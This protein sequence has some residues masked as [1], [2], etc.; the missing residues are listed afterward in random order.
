MK[1]IKNLL[2]VDDDEIFTYLTRKTIEDT[3]LVD[4]IKV[5]G[6][7]QD[8]IDFLEKIAND[9]ELLPEVILLDINM[10]ILDG[11]GFLEEFILLKPH[12]EKRIAIYM[13]TTSISPHDFER[14]K[15]ISEVSDFIVKPITKTGFINMLKNAAGE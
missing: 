8:A 6:N 11:W 1:S 3:N 13:V 9:K 12:L 14:A 4:Q 7:G 15:N 5:L 10:P 2:L